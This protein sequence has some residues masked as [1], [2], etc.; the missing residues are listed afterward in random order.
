M[1]TR[2]RKMAAM[3]DQAMLFSFELLSFEGNYERMT[4]LF[5]FSATYEVIIRYA[6]AMLRTNKKSFLNQLLNRADHREEEAFGKTADSFIA[7]FTHLYE[8]LLQHFSADELADAVKS[9]S[10][11]ASNYSLNQFTGFL[12]KKLFKRK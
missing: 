6:E 3:S 9:S 4:N 5:N 8:I 11:V 7:A 12:K 10:N 1:F 2:S